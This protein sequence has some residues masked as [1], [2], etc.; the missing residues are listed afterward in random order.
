MITLAHTAGGG[1]SVSVEFLLIAGAL[2]VVG[3]VGFFQKSVKPVVS[4]VLVVAA[5]ALGAGAFAFSGGG[6]EGGHPP[7]EG[8]RVAIE[9]P[10][11]GESV[12][13]NEP[14]DVEIDLENFAVGAHAAHTSGDSAGHVH[15]FVD[16]EDV[17]MV[18]STSIPIELEPGDHVITVELVDVEHL[19]FEPAVS[20]TVEVTAG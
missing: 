20:D 19:P 6:S 16:G 8:A 10:A 7:P 11:E 14:F 13:A 9:A 18:S 12:P 15:V 1:S 5:F 3:I 4:I 17:A 2:A